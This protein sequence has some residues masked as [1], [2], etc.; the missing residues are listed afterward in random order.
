MKRPVASEKKGGRKKASTVVPGLEDNFVEIVSEHVAGDPQREDVIWTCLTPTEI[1]R[2][3]E[4]RGT[5]VCPDTVRSMLDDFGFSRRKPE[6]VKTMGE[7][8]HHRGAQLAAPLNGAQ[9]AGSAQPQSPQRFQ[10]VAVLLRRNAQVGPGVVLGDHLIAPG[11]HL[12]KL[13][14]LGFQL[15]Q[16]L[17]Q[18][19]HIHDAPNLP[20][21]GSYLTVTPGVRR[22][23]PRTHRVRVRQPTVS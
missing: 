3:L 17:Q 12:P 11:Q 18:P 13:L 16:P 10:Q 6:K 23:A 21:M 15:F 14:N 20:Q 1:A 2:R 4:Q 9:G 22:L 7:S 5:P 8:R 19:R